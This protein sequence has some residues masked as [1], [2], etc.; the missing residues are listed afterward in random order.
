MMLTL[1]ATF[2]F[3]LGDEPASSAFPFAVCRAMERARLRVNDFVQ[4]K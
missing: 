4:Y 3:L 1:V 2:A